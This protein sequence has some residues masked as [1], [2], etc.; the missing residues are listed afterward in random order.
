[1]RLFKEKKRA[2]PEGTEREVN[3]MKKIRM[4]EEATI[5]CGDNLT[6][7]IAEQSDGVWNVDLIETPYTNQSHNTPQVRIPIKTDGRIHWVFL[8]DVL[9]ESLAD[10]ATNGG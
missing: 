6:I 5:L 2:S 10:R 7:H 8:K 1:M 9:K 4:M 3:S